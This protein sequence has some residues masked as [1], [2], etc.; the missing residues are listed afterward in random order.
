MNY[1]KLNIATWKD[2]NNVGDFFSG[3]Q[4][5]WLSNKDNEESSL[6]IFKDKSGYSHFAIEATNINKN[7]LETPKVNGLQVLLISYGFNNGKVSQF[8]DIM[9]NISGYLE[10][11]TEVVKEIAKA[12]LENGVSPLIA[13]NQTINSWISFWARQRRELLTEE[14]QVG[15]ICELLILKKL[16]KINPNLALKAWI[17]PLGEKHD[18]NFTD[19][20]FEVK[21][22]RKTERAHIINGIDQLKPHKN[23]RLAFV[24]YLLTM[25]ENINSVNLTVLVESLKNDF[26]QN[27]P[28]MT[29]KFNELLSNAGYNPIHTEEY[30]KFN[31]EVVESTFFEVNEEFPKLTSNMIKEPLSSRVSSIDYVISLEGIV[32]IDLRNLS[33]GNYFY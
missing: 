5:T 11:F 33:W 27:Q 22:T 20:T 32:G 7:D 31:V 23:K 18:F 12:I 1:K 25:T 15:L 2:L 21:G 28:T 6:H 3:Y 30:T 13:V 16:C 17:G 14:E 9:C 24:S 10:E 4:S 19:W 29:I 8:I 26:F